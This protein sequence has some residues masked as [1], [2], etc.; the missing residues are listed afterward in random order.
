[1]LELDA[2]QIYAVLVR[3]E[4]EFLIVGGGAVAVHGFPRATK[5]VDVVPSPT[6]D[7][8]R[9]LAAALQELDAE[10]LELGDF[11]L[12]EFPELSVENL[13]GGGSWCLRTRHGRLDILPFVDGVLE[14]PADY[15]GMAER[16]ISLNLPIGTVRAIGFEDLVRFKQ[17][18]GRDIDL[19]DLRALYEARGDTG[20][21]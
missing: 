13:A 15:A 10:P 9:R 7:N 19:T 12:D 4:V 21:H 5:D 18:A 2:E 1:M 20:P 6:L 11:Q 16:S 8:L 3:H 14:T 17:R